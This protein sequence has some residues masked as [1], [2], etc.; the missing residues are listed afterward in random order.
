MPDEPVIDQWL[1]EPIR[2]VILPTSVSCSSSIVCSF[3]K[4]KMG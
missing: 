4:V 2:A 1:G 3:I